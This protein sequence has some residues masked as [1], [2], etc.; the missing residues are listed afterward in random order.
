MAIEET[1][2]LPEVS[3]EDRRHIIAVDCWCGPW[4]RT[5]AEEGHRSVR[6][7]HPEA[8]EGVDDDPTL[9]FE[10]TS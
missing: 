2:I 10:A 8:T 6:H 1:H 7:V 9:D 3:S 5:D 4:V